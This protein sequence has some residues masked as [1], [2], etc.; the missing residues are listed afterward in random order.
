MIYL[1]RFIVYLLQL[2]HQEQPPAPTPVEQINDETDP[3]QAY[4]WT[5]EWQAAEREADEDIEAG[6]V[7][8]YR[9]KEAFL[10][11]FKVRE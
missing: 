10:D 7:E 1:K 8:R 5:P 4:F 6:R 3:D 2:S 9:S 11:S